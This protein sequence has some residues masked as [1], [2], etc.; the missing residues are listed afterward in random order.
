MKIGRPIIKLSH[1][2]DDHLILLEQFT[3]VK[4]SSKNLAVGDNASLVLVYN[5]AGGSSQ[6]LLAFSMTIYMNS[7]FSRVHFFPCSGV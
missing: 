7:L 5:H 4:T 6:T 3:M 2:A 1:F